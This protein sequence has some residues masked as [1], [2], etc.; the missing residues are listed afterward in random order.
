[1][2]KNNSKHKNRGKKALIVI[3]VIILAVLSFHGLFK[4]YEYCVYTAKVKNYDG[5]TITATVDFVQP[6]NFEGEEWTDAK[7]DTY[8]SQLA[9]AGYNT[10]ILQWTR[11]AYNGECYVYYPTANLSTVYSGTIYTDNENVLVNV[12]DGAQRNDFGVY[13][14]LSVD[15]NWWDVD[16]KLNFKYSDTEYLTELATIDNLMI[17]EIS[18]LYG[19]YTAF[20]GWYWAH[21]L[22]TSIN[23]WCVDWANMLNLTIDHLTA[24]DDTRPVMFSPYVHWILRGTAYDSYRMWKNFFALA[25]FREGDIFCP[26][27]GVAKQNAGGDV[28]YNVMYKTYTYIKACAEA[29]QTDPKLRFWVNCEIYAVTKVEISPAEDSLINCTLDRIKQQ[30]AIAS[31]FTDTIVTFSFTHYVLPDGTNNKNSDAASYYAD[32]IDFA[33]SCK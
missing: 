12:L 24:I 33:Q 27:D 8:Y 16:S 13:I 31:Q 5:E 32:Y 21:E 23:S 17:D 7:Y 6:F 10:I 20:K 18:A 1:M 30:Y 2:S 14:G 4:I 3:A 19:D 26:Q 9:A 22:L 25:H 28:D 11:T 29:A 15:S